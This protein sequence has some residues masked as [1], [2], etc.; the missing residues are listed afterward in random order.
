[1]AEWW[2]RPLWDQTSF[3]TEHS[4]LASGLHYALEF[5]TNEL[6][7]WDN[8]PFED[9]I[10]ERRRG[11][12]LYEVVQMLTTQPPPGMTL[13]GVVRE[14]IGNPFRPVPFEEVLPHL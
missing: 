1:M 8:F 3:L 12:R 7:G 9:T 14:V 5:A 13:P 2:C 4:R 10:R 11:W 6:W